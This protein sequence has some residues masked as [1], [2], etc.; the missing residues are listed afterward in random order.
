MHAGRAC[1]SPC[2]KRG[3]H[4]HI[5]ICTHTITCTQGVLSPLLVHIEKYT[6]VVKSCDKVMGTHKED[7]PSPEGGDGSVDG[8]NKMSTPEHSKRGESASGQNSVDGTPESTSGQNSSQIRRGDDVCK[9]SLDFCIEA[10]LCMAEACEQIASAE[11]V[12]EERVSACVRGIGSAESGQRFL[13]GVC[14]HTH[15]HVRVDKC[16]GTL[17]RMKALLVHLEQV[18]VYTV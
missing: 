17:A 13:S 5:H 15:T 6:Q 7:K 8:T 4:T 18:C 12:I 10:L 11:G 3:L 2:T 1:P 14:T 9:Q 16:G